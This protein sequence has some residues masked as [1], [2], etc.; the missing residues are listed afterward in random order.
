M[1]DVKSGGNAGGKKKTN[2]TRFWNEDRRKLAD[3]SRTKEM[4]HLRVAYKNAGS[5]RS[6][7]DGQKMAIRLPGI[8]ITAYKLPE[9]GKRLLTGQ[10]KRASKDP[11]THSI[12]LNTI[13]KLRGHQRHEQD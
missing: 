6:Q 3:K 12:N 4:K 1:K 8:L 2:N 10:Q 13:R 7:G 11:T 9:G 5:D